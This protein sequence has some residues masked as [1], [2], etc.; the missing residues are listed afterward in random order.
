MDEVS[1]Y[2]L[3]GAVIWLLLLLILVPGWYSHPVN[4]QPLGHQVESTTAERPLVEHVYELPLQSQQKPVE[5]HRQPLTNQ[6]AI[7]TRAL[8]ATLSEPNKETYIAP[9]QKAPKIMP[10]KSVKS[11]NTVNDDKSNQKQWIV[12]I[13]A[14][15]DI[16]KANQLL[17]RLETNYEV[18]IKEFKKS[19]IYSVRTGPY[20][21]KAK[22]E[23]DKRK[24]DKMLRTNA[25]VV[26]LN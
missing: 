6:Q 12:R 18:W 2:R 11:V 8:S 10:D 9:R 15:K 21:T 16:K 14:Y 4:F 23:Q 19:E 1:K 24:L 13:T 5:I 3:T 26:Q 25:E 7:K 22:A 20:I 17:G